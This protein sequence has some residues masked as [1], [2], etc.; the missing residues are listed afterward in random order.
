[1]FIAEVSPTPHIYANG[2]QESQ[3]ASEALYLVSI[4]LV[5]VTH[6]TYESAFWNIAVKEDLVII[7]F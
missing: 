6:Q 1:M 7:Q 3:F 2:A 4:S 5:T